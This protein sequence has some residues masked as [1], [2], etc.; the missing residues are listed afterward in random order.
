VNANGF[1]PADNQAS[2]P[3]LGA[4]IVAWVKA[5]APGI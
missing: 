1:M 5:G 3:Q 2:E 4:D